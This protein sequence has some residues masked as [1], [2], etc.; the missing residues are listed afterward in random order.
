M[1]LK[2]WSR[3][4]WDKLPEDVRKKCVDHLDAWILQDDKVRL[5]ATGYQEGLFHFTAGMAIRN[6]LREVLTDDKLPVVTQSENG[7]EY[8]PS[9]NWDD[10]YTGAL[11]ELLE[12]Y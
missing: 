12:R 10:Y 6:K 7:D 11:D 1:T 5:K 8:G 3:A 4:N 9:Q 2:T